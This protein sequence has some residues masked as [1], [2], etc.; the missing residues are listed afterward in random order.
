MSADNPPDL[1]KSF[2]ISPV[3][4]AISSKDWLDYWKLQS[5]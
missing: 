2:A 3:P 5:N 4:P 1:M